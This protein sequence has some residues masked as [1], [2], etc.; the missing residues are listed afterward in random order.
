MKTSSKRTGKRG[1]VL[2]FLFLLF[3]SGLTAQPGRRTG[4]WFEEARRHYAL[5]DY[6]AA[7]DLC[8]QI[9]DRDNRMLDARLLLADIYFETHDSGREIVQLEAARQLSGMPL[10]IRRLADANLAIGN[11]N[12]A[13]VFFQQYLEAEQPAEQLRKAVDRKMESCRFAL[14][15]MQNPVEFRP[16]RL[17]ETINSPSDEY[18]PGLSI[19]QQQL[20]FTRL[21]KVPGQQVQEDFYTSFHSSG[22]WSEAVSM[23]GINTS[24]N[25]GAQSLSA[26]GKVLFFT[27]CNRSDGLGSCDIYYSVCRNN[28]WETPVNAG[29]PVNTASW[30]AQP[31]ISSDGRFLYFSSNRPGGHG[32]KDLWRAHCLGWGNDGKLR[33]GA[34]ENLGDSI[35]TTGNEISPF[36]HA[37]NKDFY[38]SS[39]YHPGM[40][41]FDLFVSRVLN[42]SVFSAPMNLGYPVNSFHDEQGLH[43]TA[44]GQTAFFASLRDSLS[45]IDIYTFQPDNTFQPT[46]ATYVKASV[47]DAETL[48]PVLADIQLINL[49]NRHEAA[50]TEVAGDNGTLLLSLP[51]GNI[52]SFSVSKEGYL[53][54]SHAFDLTE[55]KDVYDP[56]LLEILLEP[57]KVGAEMDL[58]NI[59]FQTDSFHILPES[60]PELQKLS[61]FLTEN[62]TLD[63]EI[64]GHTDDTGTAASNQELSEKRARSVATYLISQGIDGGRLQ[65]TGYGEEKPV[66]GNQTEEGRQQNRR[67]TIKIVGESLEK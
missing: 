41:G 65:S 12:K 52:Y 66:A 25:E 1:M 32:E 38:F 30:E 27:A 60:E 53:F 67:T 62:P 24:G 8:E 26:D 39:D 55:T 10:I 44:N 51:S 59:Y 16:V 7:I 35:N 48:Q 34:V 13:L 11:Y 28:R 14:L 50:R 21:V 36:I 45:G 15:A 29:L 47:K 57:L 5:R 49:N 17:P 63:V 23:P 33:W 46:P 18:W 20:I 61:A 4:R 6:T 58:H 64:Q 31:S 2:L 40:G 43:I 37:A 56:Y 22:S 54:Y 19:D 9:L 3:I 42:D